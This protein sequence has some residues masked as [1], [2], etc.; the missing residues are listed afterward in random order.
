MIN[1]YIIG[2]ST[3]ATKLADKRPE[4]GWGE[5]IHLFFDDQ[6]KFHNHAVNGRSTKSFIDEKGFEDVLKVIGSNDFLI[7]Q[8]GHNDQKKDDPNRYT[9]PFTTYQE[10]L[11]NIIDKTKE[12]GAIPIVLSSISRRNFRGKHQVDKYAVSLYPYAAK[13]LAKREKVI[14]LDIFKKTRKLYEYLNWDLSRG[15]F[16]HLGLNQHPNYPEGV[17]DNTHLNDLG[18]TVVA[19]LIAEELLFTKHA[20][21]LKAH[22]LN[23]KFIRYV[24]IKRVLND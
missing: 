2:D 19:S 18:A 22:I 23:D 17:Y 5:K 12:K 14:F 10:N 15:M 20:H 1:V 11:K 4:T 7:I 8:F 6:V 13:A 21:D 9:Y 24:D 16:L 3:A